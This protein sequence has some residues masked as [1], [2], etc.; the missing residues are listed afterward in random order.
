[1]RHY[2]LF[3]E[4]DVQQQRWLTT[5]TWCDRC[6]KAD[7]GIVEPRL[8]HENDKK[9]VAGKCTVCGGECI[10]EVVVREVSS[11]SIARETKTK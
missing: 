4:L 8:Y 3:E 2:R 6:N 9:F 11:E 1:M 7:L 5:D 10:T